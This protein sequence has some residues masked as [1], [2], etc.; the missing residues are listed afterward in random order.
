MNG[1]CSR[2][3]TEARARVGSVQATPA[4]TDDPQSFARFEAA[5]A[6]LPSSLSRLL[7]VSENYPQLKSDAN[8]RD[9][10]AQLRA[11]RTALR[12]R[13]TDISRRCKTTRRQCGRSRP[14]S[15]QAC[16]A[17]REKPNFSVSDEAA[18]ARPPRVGFSTVP[19]PASGGANSTSSKPPACCCSASSLSCRAVPARRWRFR[20]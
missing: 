9:L 4:L 16:W 2:S 3:V 20:R 5:Q 18:I 19:T 13:A 6:Q 15:L 7:V 17:T 1:T 14:I 11:L 12:W 10:P 8:F